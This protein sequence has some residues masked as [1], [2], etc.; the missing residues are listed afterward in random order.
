VD[1]LIVLGSID[2]CLNG[3]HKDSQMFPCKVRACP[4]GTSY[5]TRLLG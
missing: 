3:E 2:S 1:R 4:N 5:G